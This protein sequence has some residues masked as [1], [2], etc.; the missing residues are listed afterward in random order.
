MPGAAAARAGVMSL[1]VRRRIHAAPERVFAAWTR[2]GELRQWWGPASVR[3]VAAEVDLRIGGRYRIGNQFP[4]GEV[5][6]IS[7]EFELIEPPA[8]LVYSWRVEQRE[9][10]QERVTVQFETCQEGTLVVVTHERIADATLRERHEEGWRGCLD[11]LA[12]Y[13]ATYP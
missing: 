10:P 7:G 2:P 13:L 1:V 9:G 3:C 5:L 11:G 12:G 6:W 4:N 8:R